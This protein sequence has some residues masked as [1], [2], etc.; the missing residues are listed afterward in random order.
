MKPVERKIEA[1]KVS[2]VNYLSSIGFMP[3]KETGS[4]FYYLSPLP[5]RNEKNPSFLVRKKDGK[6]S[7]KGINFK[8]DDV[9]EL[10]ML[11]ENCTFKQSIDILLGNIHETEIKEEVKENIPSIVIKDMTEI[12]SM[13]VINE[14]KRRKINIDIAKIYCKEAFVVFP[15]SKTNNK[16]VHNFIAFKNDLG[17]YELRNRYLKISSSPKYFTRLKGR[18]LDKDIFEGFIDFLSFLTFNKTEKNINKSI[19]LNSLIYLSA[20]YPDL[21]SEGLNNMYLD[22]GNAADLALKELKKDKIKYV[23]KRDMFLMYK[24]LNDMLRNYARLM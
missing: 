15:L 9:I 4:Y 1:K 5:G 24:D 12:S 22:W 17:G 3:I 6:W 7:D 8:W 2:V 13:S 11:L 20:V 23:D 14:L 10:V 16:K 18:S 19:I 21:N